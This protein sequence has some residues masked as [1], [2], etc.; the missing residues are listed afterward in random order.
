MTPI[1]VMGASGAG[2]TTVARALATRLNRPFADADDLHPAANIAAMRSGR[3]LT[4]TDRWPWLRD[5]AAWLR[6]HPDGV[7]SCSALKRAHR[8]ILREA[9]DVMFAHLDVPAAELRRRVAARA[10]H[11]MPAALVDSQ[12]DALEPL[13]PGERGVTVAA[14]SVDGAVEA[15]AAAL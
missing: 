1:V 8:D 11:F 4:D 14:T 13:G 5:V 9:G 10:G 2:K 7:V 6:E 15:I 12:L 3:P